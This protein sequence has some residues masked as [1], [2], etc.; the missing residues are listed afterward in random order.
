MRRGC[1]PTAIEVAALV[2]AAAR[3]GGL[4][5]T[6]MRNECDGL[7]ASLDESI[8]AIRA[9]PGD[10]ARLQVSHLKCG[11][12]SVWGRAGEAIARLEAARAEGLDVAADQYPYTAAATTLATIL[13]P[14]LLGLGVEACV[15]ALGDPDVRD[16]GPRRDGPRDL[17]LG[18]R[19]GA[20]RA[21]RGSGSRSRRATRTG[22]AASLADL[23]DELHV[24]PAELAFDALVDDRL[25]VSIVIDCMSERGRRRRSWP[26][27]GSRSAPTPRAGAPATR[28]S[29][30]GVPHP[31]TYGSAPRVLGHY[32]RE[33]GILSLETRGREADVRAGRPPRPARSRASCARARSPTSSCSTP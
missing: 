15:A 1:T 32:V 14:A 20:I 29:T 9:R 27:P 8:D 31:R 19:G 25:D 17:G 5:A 28:S 16:S 11:S 33:R 4:Y 2:T 22:P 30:P 24:D 23:A 12:R 6:H 7:F 21:G 10:G 13:P 18:E 26:C 3:R